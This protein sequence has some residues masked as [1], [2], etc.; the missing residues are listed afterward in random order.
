MSFGA[1]RVFAW[2]ATS[3]AVSAISGLPRFANR[4]I[5]NGWALLASK[6]VAGLL[7]ASLGMFAPGFEAAF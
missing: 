4:T 6:A 1:V 7:G 3:G 5:L 2:V